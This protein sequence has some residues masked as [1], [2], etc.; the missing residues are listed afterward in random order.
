M[1]FLNQLSSE[2]AFVWLQVELDTRWRIEGFTSSSRALFNYRLC[3]LLWIEKSHCDLMGS[4]F[5]CGWEVEQWAEASVSSV[6]VLLD[7]GIVI[8][9]VYVV[10]VYD[11][12]VETQMVHYTQ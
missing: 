5:V 12:N 2:C 4:E 6:V 9:S 11:V 8:F 10:K 7:R 3:R 1:E